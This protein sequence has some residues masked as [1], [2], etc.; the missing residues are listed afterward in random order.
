M[1]KINY[2]ILFSFFTISAYSQ[3]VSQTE[4]E[5][6]D[7]LYRQAENWNKGNFEGFMK[8]YWESDS[9]MY[10]GSGGIKYGWKNTLEG[11]KKRYPDEATRGKLVFDLLRFVALANDSY[12]VVGKWSL[13]R[14][15][16]D[17]SGHFSLIWKKINGEWVI[18]ADHSS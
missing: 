13:T 14:S 3:V 18:V 17:V 8:G 2:L 10:I 11:Y 5:I 16:G 4:R 6:A 15:I 1:S 9:L 12:F 7:I